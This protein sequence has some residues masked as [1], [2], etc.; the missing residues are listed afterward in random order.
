M[1]IHAH[2]THNQQS[3]LT[4]A[5]SLTSYDLCRSQLLISISGDVLVVVTL[6]FNLVLFGVRRLEIDG[7][8]RALD[9][10]NGPHGPGLVEM[11]VEILASL[12]SEGLEGVLGVDCQGDVLAVYQL[13]K[14]G[15]T[16]L[17]WIAKLG[18]RDHVQDRSLTK[19][20]DIRVS[21]NSTLRPLQDSVVKIHVSKLLFHCVRQPQIQPHTNETFSSSLS[22]AELTILTL[23]DIEHT[24]LIREH[25]RCIR[26][27]NQLFPLL[28][29]LKTEMQR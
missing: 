20:P 18:G 10:V 15:G 12:R 3:L 7:D 29:N 9:S 16:G 2:K 8:F 24:R 11:Q 25:L 21:S 17:W 13:L 19:V 6:E 23:A 5:K 22:D 26:V 1:H 4:R 14:R 28:P 27:D